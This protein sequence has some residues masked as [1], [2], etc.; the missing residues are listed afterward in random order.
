[1]E[2]WDLGYF[3]R[4]LKRTV[5]PGKRPIHQKLV[6]WE[7]GRE[8]YDGPR[9]YGYGGL[10]YDGRWKPLAAKIAAR[11]GL[12]ASC[13][14]L[15]VGCKKGF[16]L[17]DLKALLPGIRVKGLEN[18]RYPIDHAMEDVRADIVLGQYD[19]L[20]FPDGA[21]DFV[22][23]FSSIYMLNL[24]GVMDSLREIERLAR[25]R[26][27]VTVGAYRGEEGRRM[28]E[29]WSLLGTTVL[30][31]EEWMEVFRH[32]GYTGDYYFTTAESL[33]LSWAK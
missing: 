21:F 20:P 22:L 9:E 30:H 32:V 10:G 7:L 6:A 26:S 29:A 5:S 4:S 18:S 3:D 11:Y 19:Q 1:M 23:A 27:Y 8:F 33:N 2:E 14:V 16:F 24:R 13:A 28:F 15:E 12:S 31:V 17:H 25:G